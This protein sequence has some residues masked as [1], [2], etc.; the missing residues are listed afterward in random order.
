[1]INTKAKFQKFAGGTSYPSEFFEE[2]NM[3]CTWIYLRAIKSDSKRP[4]LFE[5]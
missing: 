4:G 1:M 5:F 2:H 3:L